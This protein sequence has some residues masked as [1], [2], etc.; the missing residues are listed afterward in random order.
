MK[1]QKIISLYL[2]LVIVFIAT[3]MFV[4]LDFGKGN[5]G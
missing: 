4:V 3:E 1:T 5:Y 2:A